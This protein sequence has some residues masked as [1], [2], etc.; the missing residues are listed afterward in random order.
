MSE[1]EN[2]LIICSAIKVELPDGEIRIFRGHRHT[3][4][5]Q[6]MNDELSYFMNRQEIN[7][8]VKKT[9][10]FMTSN[11]EFVDRYQAMK[12]FSKINQSENKP[13]SG[14]KLY[15]ENLY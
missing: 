9:Q 11:N 13:L 4:C 1:S 15:S 2:I 3:H 8:S 14:N 5:I 7:K 10:G 12:I 6:A